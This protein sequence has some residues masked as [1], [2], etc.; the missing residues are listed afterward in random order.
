MYRHN[1]DS[2]QESESKVFISKAEKEKFNNYS[3][4]FITKDETYNKSEL[5]Q[6]KSNL[7]ENTV[8]ANSAVPVMCVKNTVNG[9]VDD[10]EVF[11]DTINPVKYTSFMGEYTPGGIDDTTGENITDSTR[12]RT[13]EY[14]NCNERTEFTF[15]LTTTNT[16]PKV[17]FYDRSKN[18]LSMVDSTITS[19]V[20]AP[21]HAKYA[22]ISQTPNNNNYSRTYRKL[23]T[24]NEIT[25]I[26]DPIDDKENMFKVNIKSVGKNVFSSKDLETVLNTNPTVFDVHLNGTGG[27]KLTMKVDNTSGSKYAHIYPTCTLKPGTKYMF[28]CK[29]SYGNTNNV[30]NNLQGRVRIYDKRTDKTIV[31]LDIEGNNAYGSVAFVAPEHGEV[32]ISL[33]VVTNQHSGVTFEPA[34]AWCLWE[35]FMIHEFSTSKD[36]EEYK[37]SECEI[38]LPCQLEKVGN[39]ADRLFKRE[40]GVW[41]VE[42]HIETFT[43][44]DYQKT[45]NDLRYIGIR[46]MNNVYRGCIQFESYGNFNNIDKRY[47]KYD[48]INNLTKSLVNLDLD[49]EHA[50]LEFG[51]SSTYVVLYIDK[52]KIDQMQGA[53]VE[54][55]FARYLLDSNA[56]FKFN[57]FY[58]PRTIELPKETQVKLNSFEGCTH[59]FISNRTTDMPGRIKA[60]TP[61]SL[62]SSITSTAKKIN[63]L[64][65]KLS[66]IKKID[67]GQTIDLKSKNGFLNISQAKNGILGDV[68]IEASSGCT[69]PPTWRSPTA[70]GS[71]PSV[72]GSGRRPQ[73]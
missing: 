24:V 46:E 61:N 71:S 63:E 60:S 40:D 62:Q 9:F 25:S 38:I 41:C 8:S 10:I 18:F 19:P 3:S 42:K 73:R 52:S 4:K 7:V 72:P 64:E 6:I 2:I 26:G 13:E 45:L 15:D 34:G 54:E 44:S 56:T 70:P 66:D 17:Y 32:N 16:N 68:K 21:I 30:D 12:C 65:T 20:I 43:V 14:F 58:G 47:W 59:V 29:R 69:T 23:V 35:D 27:I 11:G 51:P 48:C 39:F 5:D 22:R 49:E 37:S 55:K 57:S 53:N 28:T 36:Y 31:Y 50:F 67:R 1:V 33:Y